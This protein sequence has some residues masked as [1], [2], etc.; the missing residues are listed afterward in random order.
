MH[1]SGFVTVK[2]EEVQT[3]CG[4]ACL[5]CTA[6]VLSQLKWH[7]LFVP[8]KIEETKKKKRQP[9]QVIPHWW[10]QI[11]ITYEYFKVPSFDYYQSTRNCHAAKK[12]KLFNHVIFLI[13][14]KLKST[15][16]L[17]ISN[18]V[19]DEHLEYLSSDSIEKSKIINN[20]HFNSLAIEFFNSLT[21]SGTSN[22]SMKLKVGSTIM[23][24]INLR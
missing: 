19:I 7:S 24:L 4:G 20:C 13:Y 9:V 17:S 18:M 16:H 23:L 1:W 5:V 12:L 14:G 21:T 2:L 15:F 10:F 3:T 11:S 6:V 22:H 8:S